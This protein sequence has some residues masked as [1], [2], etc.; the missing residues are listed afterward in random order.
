M[1]LQRTPTE[2]KAEED[3][4]GFQG[5]RAALSPGQTLSFPPWSPA[6]PVLQA[7]QELLSGQGAERRSPDERRGLGTSGTPATSDI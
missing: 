2:D 1:W 5:G 7:P 3:A 6:S 4:L